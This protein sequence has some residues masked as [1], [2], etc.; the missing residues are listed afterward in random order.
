MTKTNQTNNELL[1]A[2]KANT[3]SNAITA[4]NEA[5]NALITRDPDL[6]REYLEGSAIYRFFH[7]SCVAVVASVA[8]LAYLYEHNQIPEFG[9]DAV[10]R[11][12][13]QTMERESFYDIAMEEYKKVPDLSLITVWNKLRN[14]KK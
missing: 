4:Y 7:A 1:E 2:I 12:I 10:E 5:N 13:R 11:I 3:F 8:H 14:K 9:K 6:E